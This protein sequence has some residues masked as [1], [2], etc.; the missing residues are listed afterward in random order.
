MKLILRNVKIYGFDP[1]SYRNSEYDGKTSKQYNVPLY[2]SENDKNLIDSYIFGK[3]SKNEKDEF[4]FY[5][6]SKTPIPFFDETGKKT[7]KII[8]EV[9]LA[10]VSI[11]ID[12]FQKKNKSGELEFEED[13]S[14]RIV[15]YSKCLGIRYISK[16]EN[17]APKI[18]PKSYDTYED[19]FG[20]EDVIQSDSVKK[21]IFKEVKNNLI[22]DVEPEESKPDDLPF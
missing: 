9:F 7:S 3:T 10:D 12:E 14:P 18:P 8:N 4:V 15:R 2:I 1:T 22:E 11:L 19:I 6:T 5:G 13:G 21:P 20:G 16:I 17:E